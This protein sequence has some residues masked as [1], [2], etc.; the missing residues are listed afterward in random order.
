MQFG[1]R[2]SV[3]VADLLPCRDAITPVG[4]GE[5]HGAGEEIPDEQQSMSDDNGK[6]KAAVE[7]RRHVHVVAT[8]PELPSGNGH[9]VLFDAAQRSVAP[10]GEKV[11]VNQLVE[12]ISDRRMEV[13]GPGADRAEIFEPP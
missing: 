3:V 1:L 7:G 9:A 12:R 13:G 8:T 2:C 4:I 6:R 10:S 11:N 5:C